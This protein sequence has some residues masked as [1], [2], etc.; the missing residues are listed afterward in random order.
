MSKK[1]LQRPTDVGDSDV[2]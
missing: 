2:K 1:S